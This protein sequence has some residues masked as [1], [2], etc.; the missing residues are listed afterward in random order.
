MF[1]TCSTHILH[2]HISHAYLLPPCRLAGDD[3]P[4]VQ[5]LVDAVFAAQEAAPSSSSSQIQQNNSVAAAATERSNSTAAET[6]AAAGN[7]TK[8][9]V[10]SNGKLSVMLLVLGDGP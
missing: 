3:F 1:H 2:T 8:E 5:S 4:N 9:N 6:A 7:A 10:S